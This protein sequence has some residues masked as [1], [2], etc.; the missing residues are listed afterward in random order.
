MRKTGQKFGA[1]S[2]CGLMRSIRARG[3]CGRCYRKSLYRGVQG[4]VFVSDPFVNS[5]FYDGAPG[6]STSI[7]PFM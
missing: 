2:E 4:R 1:C 5:N 6:W 3:L 7:N